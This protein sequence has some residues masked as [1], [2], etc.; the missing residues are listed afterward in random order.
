MEEDR[1]WDPDQPE[2]EDD[3]GWDPA[4]P[5]DLGDHLRNHQYEDHHCNGYNGDD[6]GNYENEDDDCHGLADDSPIDIQ[7][8]NLNIRLDY[9]Y[10]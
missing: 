2:P 8:I 9:N 6:H 10:Y 1:V 5:H 7:D 4:Q 3:S